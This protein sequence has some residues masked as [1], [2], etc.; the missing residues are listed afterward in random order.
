[1]WMIWYNKYIS[2]W[3]K[4]RKEIEIEE[5]ELEKIEWRI[6]KW[7]MNE[8]MCRSKWV[9]KRSEGRKEKSVEWS[10]VTSEER[11][12]APECPGWWCGGSQSNEWLNECNKMKTG[13]RCMQDAAEGV[14]YAVMLRVAWWLKDV[15][16]ANVDAIE[17]IRGRRGTREDSD[18]E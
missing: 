17:Q 9:R 13:W 5:T 1:M 7:G 2:L 11:M 4:E 12:N 3:K 10:V 8:W 15:N 18:P 16:A 6:Y 14:L